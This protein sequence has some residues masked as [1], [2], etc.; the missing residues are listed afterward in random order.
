[1]IIAPLGANTLA[2][3]VNGQC[4][5]LLTCVLRAWPYKKQVDGRW[6]IKKPVIAAPA[7]NTDMYEHPT[8]EKQ[9]RSL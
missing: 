8:T 4:D 6:V 1:M 3:I 9:L 5:N 7:M 2:K